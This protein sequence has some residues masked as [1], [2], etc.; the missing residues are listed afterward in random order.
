VDSSTERVPAGTGSIVMSRLESPT[1]NHSREWSGVR[2]RHREPAEGREPVDRGRWRPAR[3]LPVRQQPNERTATPVPPALPRQPHRAS[4]RARRAPLER[5]RVRQRL[6]GRDHGRARPQ[7]RLL[8]LR[9]ESRQRHGVPRADAA[10]PG[11][12]G[13]TDRPG[14]PRRPSPPSWPSGTTTR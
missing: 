1:D 4:G 13:P 12:P 8:G 2:N 9:G 14:D 3:L 6:C 10:P 11:R 7:R 5:R